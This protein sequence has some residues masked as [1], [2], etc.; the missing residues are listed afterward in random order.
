MGLG[1][2]A[3]RPRMP[4]AHKDGSRQEWIL[5][6]LPPGVKRGQFPKG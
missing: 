4:G 1:K 3:C 2:T 5:L 6:H